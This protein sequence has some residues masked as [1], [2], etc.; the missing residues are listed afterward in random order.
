MELVM[1]LAQA[2]AGDMSI[3]L[4]GADAAVAQKFLYDAQIRAIL[5]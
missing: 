4:G 1:H 5:Q 3:D 2:F